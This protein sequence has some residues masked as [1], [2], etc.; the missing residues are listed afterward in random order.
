MRGRDKSGKFS[1]TPAAMAGTCNHIIISYQFG[2]YIGCTKS[3]DTRGRRYDDKAPA[4]ARS[5]RTLPSNVRARVK[6]AN[7]GSGCGAVSARRTGRNRFRRG[8]L[9]A[10]PVTAVTSRVRS[11]LS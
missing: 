5:R 11:R 7:T 3:G 8:F 4:T 10:L 9:A 1:K 6:L 2:P